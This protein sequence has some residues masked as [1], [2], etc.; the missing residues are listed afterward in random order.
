MHCTWISRFRPCSFK[1]NEV[2]QKSNASPKLKKI[3]NT[4]DKNRKKS[5]VNCALNI[6]AFYLDDIHLYV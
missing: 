5:I 1:K 2:K 4:T 6:G 3:Q